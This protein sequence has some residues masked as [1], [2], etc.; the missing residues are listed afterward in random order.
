MTSYTHLLFD[1]DGT[2]TDS[3]EGIINALRYAFNKAGI[4]ETSTGTLRSFIGSPLVKTIQ[5][6]YAVPKEDAEQIAS[7]YRSYYTTKGVYESKLYPGMSELLCDLKQSGRRLIVATSKR[8]TGAEQ[9]LDIFRLR[10]YFDLVV[11]GSSDG[12]IS[13]KTD[14]I[15]EVFNKTGDAIKDGA[16]MIGDR[17]YDILGARENGIDSIAVM[18]GY[19]TKEEIDEANPTYKVGTVEELRVLL[20]R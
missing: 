14:V 7:Y 17:K 20:L 1:L 12:K 6:V 4:P 15:R 3:E 13:E 18:Y 5:E 16:V 2:I 10:E 11:G 19:G 8:T 9:V